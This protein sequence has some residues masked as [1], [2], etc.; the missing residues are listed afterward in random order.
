MKE[1]TVTYKEVYEWC[2]EDD[3]CLAAIFLV[4]LDDVKNLVAENIELDPPRKRLFEYLKNKKTPKNKE[5]VL[6]ITL[7][8]LIGRFAAVSSALYNFDLVQDS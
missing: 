2:L 7:H 1:K 3:E 4:S 8:R 5:E 6:R